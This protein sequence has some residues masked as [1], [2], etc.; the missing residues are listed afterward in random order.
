[1]YKHTNIKGELNEPQFQIRPPGSHG[2]NQLITDERNYL[3]LNP[4][5]QFYITRLRSDD[6]LF[7]INWLIRLRN[8]DTLV[9]RPCSLA[10]V[11]F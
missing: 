3:K 4:F 6:F 5:Y 1:M 10:L 2:L 11:L 7:Q 8:N 9:K